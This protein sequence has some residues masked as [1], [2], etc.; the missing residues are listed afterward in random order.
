MFSNKLND[1]VNSSNKKDVISNC[2]IKN[3]TSPQLLAIGRDRVVGHS[4]PEKQ[5]RN[6]KGDM[7]DVSFF[8]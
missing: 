4:K 2:Q 7:S 6:A 3:A 8:Y 5:I 1:F